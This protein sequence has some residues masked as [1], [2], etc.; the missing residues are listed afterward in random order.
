M[1][2]CYKEPI[3]S[4]TNGIAINP[5][6]RFKEPIYFRM[7]RGEQ[8]AIVG[9]NG[10]GK[11]ILV[12][13]LTGRY[14]LVENNLQ[15]NQSNRRLTKNGKLE[16]VSFCDSYAS[17]DTTFY[18]QQRWN[19]TE[20]DDYLKIKDLFPSI[21][22]GEWKNELF[23]LL[24]I[25]KIW[26]KR[27]VSLSSG[28]NRR[29]Q[30]AKAL[31]TH[32][33][34]IVIDNPFIGLDK[35]ARENL[36][37]LLTKMVETWGLHII[38]VV[39]RNADI[40]GFITHVVRVERMV[41]GPKLK[42]IEYLNI[43]SD[44]VSYKGLSVCAKQR[45][46]KMRTNTIEADVIVDFK[47]ISLR[48]ADKVIFNNL[49]WV[50]K[51]G[52]KWALLGPNGSGKS[53]LLSL[54]YADNPQSYACQISLFGKRRGTGESIWDIKKRIG[55]VS[56]ELHRSYVRHIFVENVI[57]SGLSDSIGLY[58]KIS[59]KERAICAIWMDIFGI[60]AFAGKDFLTLSS[61]EQRLALL[62]RAFVKDPLLLILDEPLHGL[63][64]A[65]RKLVMNIIQSFS[66]SPEKTLIMVT[67]YPEELPDFI[68][69]SLRLPLSQ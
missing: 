68:N 61:G 3:I 45:I 66:D 46:T 12:S 63:D 1:E 21:E 60:G 25:N 13:T 58:R 32:P 9:P 4:L 62:A 24:S 38:T 40:A 50:V 54:I 57:A 6:F 29:F 55:Y 15:E 30:L 48:Y 69:H 42:K 49:D 34:I 16:L 11:S 56:P 22:N 8:I 27:I 7:E 39:S 14:P 37:V 52:E 26:D 20:I 17:T 43:S 67:H 28:E 64:S 5:L 31:S 41:C 23:N 19:V 65:N 35:E 36:C 53:A 2:K 33:S 18:Y 59:N 10:S 47:G 44:M 51:N